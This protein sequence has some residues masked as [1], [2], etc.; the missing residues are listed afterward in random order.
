MTPRP[1][2]SM[3]PED[4]TLIAGTGRSGSSW[5][6]KLFDSS[7][8]VFYKHEPDN[9]ASKPWFR[10]IPSRL[11][12]DPENDRYAPRF[13]HA[14]EESFWHHSVLMI[15][16]PEFSKSFLRERPW[17]VLNLGLRALRKVRL[18]HQPTLRI[19]GWML[20]G[21]LSSVHY[22]WKSVT[23]NLRLCWIH[24]H[25]PRMRLVL[26]VRHPGGYLNSWMRG[27]RYEGWSGFGDR[28]RLDPVV[29]PFPLP[30]QERF[31]DVY[32]NGTAF[33][34]EL[35]YWIVANETPLLSLADSG[36]LKL[37][38]YEDLCRRPEAVLRDVFDYCGIRLEE[39]T[40]QFAEASTSRHDTRYHAVFKDPSRTAWRWREDL[41]RGQHRTLERLLRQ[42]SLA[43][44]WAKDASL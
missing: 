21:D 29:L 31:A 23:S 26:I 44:L 1:Q 12:P 22:A 36:A 2:A 17:Q 39:Q 10:E 34:R 27:A 15:R 13:A 40:R 33:E 25:F 8:C 24:R 19:P 7:P 4:I 18:P 38:I 9:V 32:R 16:P 43:D 6:G 3:L 30:E 20:R 28:N 42:T 35:V 37:V 41:D 14:L 5:L 11:D